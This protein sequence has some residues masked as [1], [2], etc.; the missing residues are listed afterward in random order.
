MS[1]HCTSSYVIAALP[2]VLMSLVR[3]L[4]CGVNL[5]E[6]VPYEKRYYATVYCSSTVQKLIQE[7]CA[8]DILLQAFPS[9]P[10][11]PYITV[12]IRSKTFP[13]CQI[14]QYMYIIEV[15]YVWLCVCT[16]KT[17][18]PTPA[19]PLGL[20]ALVALHSDT[21]RRIWFIGGGLWV[22]IKRE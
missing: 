17:R 18:K 13:T 8:Y 7:V 10:L 11:F 2:L 12:N 5:I 4:L 3:Q 1:L 16:D 19:S 9:S 22:E 21:S 14:D 15:S 6:A 20:Y